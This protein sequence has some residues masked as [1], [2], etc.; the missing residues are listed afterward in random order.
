MHVLL[1][2]YGRKKSFLETD[3]C[4]RSSASSVVMKWTKQIMELCP[5]KYIIPVLF[6]IKVEW[7]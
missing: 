1:V 6:S 5:Q 4:P 2:K 3:Y 7:C